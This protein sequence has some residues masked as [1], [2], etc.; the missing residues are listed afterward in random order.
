MG[1][2]TGLGVTVPPK[3]AQSGEQAGKT[4][5]AAVMFQGKYTW[6]THMVIET[7]EWRDFRRYQV[8]SAEPS[9]ASPARK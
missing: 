9:H 2:L 4:C 8:G 1:K 5:K 7:N 6:A 3:A